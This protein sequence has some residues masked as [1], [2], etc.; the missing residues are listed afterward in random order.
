MAQ[1]HQAPPPRQAPIKPDLVMEGLLREVYTQFGNVDFS[2]TVDEISITL[3]RERLVEACQVA[4]KD[5][6]LEFDYLRCLAVTEYPEHF[7]AI[8]LLYSTTKSHKAI[9]KANAPRDDPEI[10]SVTG[11]WKGA[12]W[13]EREGA[14]L[15]GVVFSGHPN[16]KQLLL[17]DEFDGKYPL[18][19]DYPFEEIAE[20]N[21]EREPWKERP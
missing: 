6:R 16:P 9:L 19:K 7:Q 18:R 12:D 21:Q 4:K 11:V 15:F 8:Y 20:W 13:H 2:Y 17:F 5:P 1:P 10:P 3:P 14:E